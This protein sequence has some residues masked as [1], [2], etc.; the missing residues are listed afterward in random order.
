MLMSQSSRSTGLRSSSASA[1]SPSCAVATSAPSSSSKAANALAVS[2]SSSTT[3]MRTPASDPARSRL[4]LPHG[5]AVDQ[6]QPDAHPRAPPSPVR[7]R[8]HAS[9]MHL[10]KLLDQRKTDA[11]AAAGLAARFDSLREHLEDML[12][13]RRVNPRPGIRDID[14]QLVLLA[15]KANR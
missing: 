2:E 4:M 14:T 11:H 1:S 6:R 10:H 13:Q 5:M 9:R 15:C 3:S 8:E 12:Q 7:M